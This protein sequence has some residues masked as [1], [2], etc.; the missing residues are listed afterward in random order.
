MINIFSLP[1]CLAAAP[2][3]DCDSTVLKKVAIFSIFAMT[4]FKLLSKWPSYCFNKNHSLSHQHL[5]KYI[6]FVV[7]LM[8]ETYRTNFFPE[9]FQCRKAMPPNHH[10]KIWEYLSFLQIYALIFRPFNVEYLH[11]SRIEINA[12]Q[13]PIVSSSFAPVVEIHYLAAPYIP[14][15]VLRSHVIQMI[16][17]V[18]AFKKEF[19][20]M[21]MTPNSF[22]NTF[23]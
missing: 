18:I 13:T 10:G 22:E 14:G 7:K 20:Q 5:P 15:Q 1:L 9:L 19:K 23:S 3:E 12:Q 2:C 8:N 11:V 21:H 17:L 16:F 4:S 6:L